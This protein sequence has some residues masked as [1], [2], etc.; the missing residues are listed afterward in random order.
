M[1]EA[2]GE[3][4]HDESL[5]LSDTQS[6]DVDGTEPVTQLGEGE[7]R[8]VAYNEKRAMKIVR[9]QKKKTDEKS[10]DSLVASAVERHSKQLAEDSH[11]DSPPTTSYVP[12]VG[13]RRGKL[14]KSEVS[15]LGGLR[16]SLYFLAMVRPSSSPPIRQ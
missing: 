12:F 13:P 9:A 8:L 14:K 3:P 2:F 5:S 1:G 6:Q 15:P 16:Q 11:L 7:A 10:R 4:L